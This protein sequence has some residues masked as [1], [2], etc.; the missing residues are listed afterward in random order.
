MNERSHLLVVRV[1]QLVIHDTRQNLILSGEHDQFVQLGQRQH[2]RL[3][4]QQVH[5][6]PQNVAACFEM[7][8]V[9]SRHTGKRQV[10]PQHLCHGVV[11]TKTLKR[12]DSVT[13]GRPIC[14]G[15]LPGLRRHRHQ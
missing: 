6:G 9:R 1:K 4:H 11:A 3:F 8:V 13:R 2:G 14:L 12:T 15:P 7:P 10:L 5:S